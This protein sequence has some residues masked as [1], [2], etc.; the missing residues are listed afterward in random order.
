[1]MRHLWKVGMD[2]EIPIPFSRMSFPQRAISC[3]RRST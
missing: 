1:M 2:V 3:L